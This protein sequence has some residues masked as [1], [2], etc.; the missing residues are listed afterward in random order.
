M[1]TSPGHV[2]YNFANLVRREV[3]N[4]KTGIPSGIII[5][6]NSIQDT[7]QLHELYDAFTSGSEDKMIVRGIAEFDRPGK[8]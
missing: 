3:G 6:L 8:A 7:E 4:A 1:I 5:K 2:E